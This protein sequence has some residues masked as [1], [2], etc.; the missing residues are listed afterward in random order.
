MSVKPPGSILSVIYGLISED[1]TL[2]LNDDGSIVSNAEPSEPFREA[3]GL[4]A[5]DVA[6]FEISLE[7]RFC[8]PIPQTVSDSWESLADIANS[9][10]EYYHRSQ[11]SLKGAHLRGYR[12]RLSPVERA[13]AATRADLEVRRWLRYL[14]DTCPWH[15]RRPVPFD[16]LDWSNDQSADVEWITDEHGSRFW[17]SGSVLAEFI[18]SDV[19]Y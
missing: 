17:L 11:R 15:Q 14:E 10:T 7:E 16:D 4:D 2:V 3:L 9:I 19:A 1:L 13:S 5:S 18:E 8:R 6:E 12:I